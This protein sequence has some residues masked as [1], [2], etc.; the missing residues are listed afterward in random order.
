[1]AGLR[2]AIAAGKLKEFCAATREGWA[3]GD[4]TAAR[5]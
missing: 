2:A 4:G 3:R 1:M 5:W